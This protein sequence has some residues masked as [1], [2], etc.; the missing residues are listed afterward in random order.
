MNSCPTWINRPLAALSLRT[1][2]TLGFAMALLLIGVLMGVALWGAQR[3]E[4]A[5][6]RLHDVE[7]PI[8]EQVFHISAHLLEARRYEKEFLLRWRELGFDEARTRYVT[9]LNAH[10]AEIPPK[11]AKINRLRAGDPK[12]AELTGEIDLA[13]ADYRRD[14]LSAADLI[15]QLGHVDNGLEAD[16]RIRA[17]AIEALIPAGAPAL[18]ADLMQMRRVE[19]DYLLRGRSQDVAALQQAETR[20]RASLSSAALPAPL[21][22]KLVELTREYRKKFEEY[23]R[24]NNRIDEL[25]STYLTAVARTESPLQQLEHQADERLHAIHE[26]VKAASLRNS[27]LVLGTGA[28]AL[29]FGLLISATL[30]RS[31]VLA[32]DNSVAFA[33]KIASGDLS[34][35]LPTHDDGE[36][37]RLKLALNRMADGLQHSRDELQALNAELEQ[38]IAHRTLH[39]RAANRG[40]AERTQEMALLADLTEW[41]LVSYSSSEVHRTIGHFFEQL[42]PQS[43]GRFYLRRGD[44]SLFDSKSEWGAPCRAAPTLES[45]SCLAL[46]QGVTECTCEDHPGVACIQQPGQPRA[47]ALCMP[48]VSRSETFGLI[49]FELPATG[50]VNGNMIDPSDRMLASVIVKQVA[51]GLD[52]LRL[53]EVLRE[54]A[55]RDALT[56]L[57]NRRYLEETLAQEIERTRRKQGK[58]A[59]IML[60][61]DFFKRFNDTYGHE[62]GDVA[63]AAIGRL[64]RENVRASDVPCRFGGE[65]F[66]VLL[67]DT[68]ATL[69][70]ERAEVIRRA[71]HELHLEY[72]GKP[73]PGVTISLGAAEFPLHGETG[74]E[75]LAAADAALYR[76]KEGGRDRVEVALIPSPPAPLP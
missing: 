45:N 19:K 41:L 13:L 51:L 36:F 64:L 57:Y 59:A 29:L 74:A 6:T 7:F 10:L 44:T 23:V 54:Q 14:F 73:L 56:G 61:V 40:L 15:G 53:R 1:R 70:A 75:L 42:F 2:L 37:N 22:A 4:E 24:I 69:A 47:T 71:A 46:R 58:L 25:R 12:A 21:R 48:L 5:I 34:A 63:L 11:L 20:L 49:Y 62:A 31:I 43:A 9:L 66:T 67:P 3:A 50:G 17:H 60:D 52:N 8:E 76:A 30:W 38:R 39:L 35:R 26:Q 72:D 28:F 27:A 33:E 65:E 16:F 18:R 32:V 55:I 68:D